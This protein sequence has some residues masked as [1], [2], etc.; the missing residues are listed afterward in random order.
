MAGNPG[1]GKGLSAG[2]TFERWTNPK[3]AHYDSLD[4]SSPTH[5]RVTCYMSST[6]MN[7]AGSRQQLV[8]REIPIV[9]WILNTITKYIST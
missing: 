6:S 2:L 4:Q 8:N 5:S 3:N 9:N 7:L 1:H